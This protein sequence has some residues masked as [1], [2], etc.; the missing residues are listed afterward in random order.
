MVI[1]TTFPLD[2]DVL[3]KRLWLV[4][5]LFLLFHFWY[6][7]I[8][9]KYLKITYLVFWFSFFE[10]QCKMVGSRT[11]CNKHVQVS[12]IMNIVIYKWIMS[13]D[14]ELRV[15]FILTNYCCLCGAEFKNTYILHIRIHTDLM[16]TIF[17]YKEL[18][19]N[20]SRF[21]IDISKKRLFFTK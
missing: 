3:S 9:Q 15:Y 8:F 12:E 18:F 19:L 10:H 17:S 7:G 16:S 14:L 1:W 6:L 20:T 11:R 2:M 5:K 13:M 4:H 21:H